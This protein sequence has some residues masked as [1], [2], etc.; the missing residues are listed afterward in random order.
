MSRELRPGIPEDVGVSSA[1]LRHLAGLAEGWVAEGNASALVVF[2][3]RRG[4]IVLHEAFGRLGPE[5]DALPLPLNAIFPIASISKV[6]TA[7]AALCL[8]EDGLLSLTRPVGEYVPEFQGEAKDQVLV[9]HLLTHTAGFDDAKIG[10]FLRERKH[11]GELLDP[12]E[13]DHPFFQ[14][15]SWARYLTAAYKVP[16]SWPPGQEMSYSSYGVNL[17]GTIVDAVAGQTL[18]SFVQKRIFGPLG[19]TDSCHGFPYAASARVVSRAADAKGAHLMA[20]PDV[21]RMFH[22]SGAVCSSA[23]DLA[24]LGQMLLNRGR[25]RGNRVLGPVAVAEMTRNQIPGISAHYEDRFFPEASW[26]LGVEVKGDKKALR[27]PSLT[28]RESFCHGGG[29]GSFWLVDPTYDL[30]GVYLS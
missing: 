26:G 12:D 21:H 10:A 22:A 13:P 19:M 28:S 20:K 8:V 1:R 16:L 30:V 5:P 2:A 25:Y 4:T 6:I 27:Y 11:T 3:A 24:I 17:L 18:E 23:L 29:G 7:V 15:F 9:H 14:I